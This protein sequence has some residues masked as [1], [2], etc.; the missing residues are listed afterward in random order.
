MGGRSAR[1][2]TVTVDPAV[3]L[4]RQ[5]ERIDRSPVAVASDGGV[6]VGWR[7]LGDDPADLA[8][9]VYRDGVL[10]NPAPLT[11]ATSVLDKD[12][13]S[14][15][16]YR[17]SAVQ[18]GVERWV[19]DT[20]QVWDQQYLD[21][22]L[23]RPAGGTTP[24]GVTYTYSANDASVGDVDGDGT[25]EIV[26]KWDP[27]NS[28]DNSQAGYTGDVY[29]DAYRLDGTRLW[30]IDLGRNIRAGAHYTQFQV[31]DYDGDGRA[32]VAMKTADGTVD[33]AGTVIGDALADYRNTAGYVLAGPEYLTMFDGLTGAALDT[34]D[35]TPPR[36]N[37]GDWGDTYGN[38][39]DRFLAATAYLD[40]QHPSL[41]EARGYYTRTVVTAYDW[42]GK[43]L[44]Q[45]WNFDSDVSGSQWTSMGNHNLGIADV[46]FDGKDE[47][48]YGSMTLDDDGTGLYDTGLGHGDAIHVGDFDPTRPG[49]EVMAAHEEMDH[50][51]NRGATFRDAMTGEV[52]WSMPA[53]RDTGRAAV[54]DVDPRYSGAEGWAVGGQ[55]AAWNS[56]VGEMHAADG[57]LISTKIPAA[58][59]LTYW[60]G[61]LL[62][63]IGDHDYSDAT[64]AGVPTISKW[65]WENQRQVELYRADGTLS[66]NGTKGNFSLQADLFGD[67]REEIVTRL[68]DSS[69][70][71]IATTVI[72]T[73]YRLR[74]LMSD[75]TYRLGVGRE[76]TGYNQPPHTSY[77]IGEGM[78]TPPAPTQRYTTAAPAAG[79]AVLGQEQHEP[80]KGRLTAS[81]V[82]A[83]GDLTLTM[84]MARGTNGSMLR[85]YQD[86]RPLR[87]VLLPTDTPDAQTYAMA[88]N[89]LTAGAHTFTGELVGPGGTTP[90]FPVTVTVGQGVGG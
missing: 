78:A 9:N 79:A 8:F 40:G 14:S 11:A 86:G 41:I 62:A 16:T 65:D 63:E 12:G 2:T 75:S 72:P 82:T 44:T 15:S 87:T 55:D 31:Y 70:L 60:D 57:K 20:F 22:P 17:V 46:D 49:L 83:G 35:Y 81:A 37:V 43:N 45:R 74:T 51:G 69:A 32:E 80:G 28:K 64:G 7:L 59:F 48:V 77:Y 42:D 54:G 56:P 36:G 3:H 1:S 90:V 30:R 53:T 13:T 61:D 58:N 27:S 5:A 29:V 50:S 76:N 84:T 88:V 52:I 33:G 23:D 71:R 6:L 10:V 66:N 47:V 38:R 73:E 26:L 34:I 25:Y 24:D 39:V 68:A 89:G 21:V 67:W 4:V 19:T 18:G 85:L